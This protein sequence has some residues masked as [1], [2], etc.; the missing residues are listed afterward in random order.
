M[1]DYLQDNCYNKLQFASIYPGKG[2]LIDFCDLIRF[3]PALGEEIL[4]NFSKSLILIE[5]IVENIVDKDSDTKIKIY[6]HNL[7]PGCLLRIKDIRTQDLNKLFAFNGT[8]KKTTAVASHTV[9]IVYVCPNCANGIPIKQTTKKIKK[10]RYCA[11]GYKGSWQINKETKIDFLKLEFEELPEYLGES[12]QTQRVNVIVHG[13]L[14]SPDKAKQLEPGNK[15]MITGVVIESPDF[16]LKEESNIKEMMLEANYIE[17][18]DK[19]Y[20]DLQLTP[21]DIE[22]VKEL[23][24]DEHLFEKMRDSIAPN[25][26]GIEEIKEAL[27]LQQFGGVKKV[28]KKGKTRGTIHILLVG[29]PSCLVSG[30]R[31]TLSDGTSMKIGDMGTKHLQKIDYN[32]RIDGQYNNAKATVFHHYKKQPIIEIITESGKSLKGTHNQP[33]LCSGNNWKRFDAL[34]VGDSVRILKKIRCTKQ[35]LVET[36]WGQNLPQFVDEDLALIM[37]YV[38]TDGWA[39]KYE[40]G[41]VINDDE[42]DVLPR[43][44]SAV[45]KCFGVSL[46][47]HK[48]NPNSKMNTYTIHRKHISEVLAPL[49]IKANINRVPDVIFKSRDSVVASF[50]SAVY[51][52]DGCAFCNGRGRTSISLKSASLEFLRDVQHLLLRFGIHSRI[53]WEKNPKKNTEGIKTG[54]RGNL[55]IRQANSMIRFSDHIGFLSKKKIKKFRKNYEYANKLKRRRNGK[56]TEKVVEI[57]RLRPRDVFDIEV[58]THKRFIA[59]GIIVHNTGKSK[60]LNQIKELN[61]KSRLVVGGASTKAGITAAI[62]KDDLT[63]TYALEAGAIVLANKATL[64]LDEAD[65]MRPDDISALHEA[66]ESGVITRTGIGINASL[67]AETAILAAANPESSRF[68]MYKPLPEQVNMQSSLLSRFDAIFAFIDRADENI[69][70]KVVQRIL[71]VH[72]D[73]DEINPELERDVIRK[74]IAYAKRLEPKLTDEADKLIKEFYTGLRKQTNKEDRV[75]AIPITPRQAEGLIRLSEAAAKSRLSDKVEEQDVRLARR[76]VMFYLRQL[77]MD[78]SGRLDIDRI[79]TISASARNKVIIL[80]EILRELSSKQEIFQL[81]DVLQKA[82]EENI[83]EHETEEIINKLKIKG[84][85]IEPKRGW[86]KCL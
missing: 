65:K 16:L 20:E 57:N 24:N 53:I 86:I 37:A 21:E 76:I 48:K 79:T 6:F 69:D 3:D 10:P 33:V 59:N 27:L 14:I 5:D 47:K 72:R 45:K 23:A 49:Q 83:P 73:S 52:A 77:G 84:D 8:I 31:V 29:D 19:S 18:I 54:P 36:G 71:D 85:I 51:D 50:L 62:Y 64:L 15:V 1:T 2:L 67:P 44:E 40:V 17:P 60:L 28:S 26:Y 11:C 75:Q 78:E 7:T 30:E 81:F 38:V 41:L 55:V 58:P 82:K 46:S 34:E 56:L 43:L 12:S 13:P 22:M 42:L 66:M 74:Y 9:E 80:E 39:R 32:V 70:G 4:D 25:I 35:A 68:D 61:P 63:N